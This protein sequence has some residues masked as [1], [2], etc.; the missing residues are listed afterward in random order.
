M[1]A[2]TNGRLL[3]ITQGILDS[4]TVLVEGGRIVAVGED[5]IIQK[6]DTILQA[7][8]DIITLITIKNEKKL[9]RFI[10]IMHT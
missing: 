7:V 5:V 10:L 9:L 2:I 8:D 3:T 4:G 6:G 1:I